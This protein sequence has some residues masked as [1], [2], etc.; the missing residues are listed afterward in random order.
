MIDFIYNSRKCKL[1]YSDRKQ[2]SG[3]WG[4]VL[5]EGQEGVITKTHEETF[6]GDGSVHF[7]GCG[8]SFISV[9]LN[10]TLDISA[11]NITLY[12]VV[13]NIIL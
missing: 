3:A 10:I 1:I 12:Y 9:H 4:Q 13:L 8:N 6:I 11:P 7:L 2:V 5:R